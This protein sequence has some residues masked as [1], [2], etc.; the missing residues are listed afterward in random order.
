M[1]FLRGGYQRPISHLRNIWEKAHSFRD[2]SM[3]KGDHRVSQ[4]WSDDRYGIKGGKCVKAA[5]SV[6][7]DDRNG[8]LR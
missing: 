3:S 7:I 1:P 2:E 5:L 4:N 6:C 8:Q